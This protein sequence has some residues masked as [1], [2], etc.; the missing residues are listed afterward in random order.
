MEG[1]HGLTKSHSDPYRMEEEHLT[2]RR[3]AERRGGGGVNKE[4][5][6]EVEKRTITGRQK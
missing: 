6:E 1:V 3:W 5:K 4:I 2:G